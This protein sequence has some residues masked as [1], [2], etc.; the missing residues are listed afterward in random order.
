MQMQGQTEMNG[1]MTMIAAAAMAAA[2]AARGAEVYSVPEGER[3]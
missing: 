3:M 2:G 1:K